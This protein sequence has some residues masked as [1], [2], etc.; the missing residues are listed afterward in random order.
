MAPDSAEVSMEEQSEGF[1][2]VNSKA[3]DLVDFVNPETVGHLRFPD[4][5]T[6]QCQDAGL[7]SEIVEGGRQGDWKGS[8][9]DQ[10]DFDA[11][12]GGDVVGR[13]ADSVQEPP[14]SDLPVRGF[15][16]SVVDSGRIG[17][18]VRFPALAVA[19]RT[20]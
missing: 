10:V 14:A 6:A 1:R 5:T 7:D 2:V 20:G 4:S 3:W 11:V 18:L 19:V 8:Q 9:I 13:V 12:A 17:A 16:L 15:D